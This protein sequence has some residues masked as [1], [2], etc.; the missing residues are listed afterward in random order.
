MSGS[1][2]ATKRD[3]A[4]LAAEMARGLHAVVECFMRADIPI[5]GELL[6]KTDEIEDLVQRLNAF[7]LAL[8]E[9]E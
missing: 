8:V 9:D 5:R 1:D 6:N 4:T 2:P 7:A 3:I